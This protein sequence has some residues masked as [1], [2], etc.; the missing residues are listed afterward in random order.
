MFLIIQFGSKKTPSIKDCIVS[1]GESA[2]IVEW[3]NI[4]ERPVNLKGIVFSGSP[5]FF[6]EASHEPYKNKISPLLNWKVP[7]L[8]IC[9][10]HQL[11][12]ILYGAKIFRGQP[13]RESEKIKL[14]TKDE[15]FF[16]FT[17]QTE[18]VEDHTE[19]IDVPADFFHLASSGLYFNEAM[20]HKE[21]NFW[22]VQFHPEVSGD[23]GLLIFKNFI[24]ICNQKNFNS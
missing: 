15:L 24:T 22:G 5:T 13:V 20:K 9:F 16:G 10:G 19:G 23:S 7:I 17:E 1:L 12:G 21:K 6:T 14:L 18:M 8:G 3:E 11:L 4:Q 2:E